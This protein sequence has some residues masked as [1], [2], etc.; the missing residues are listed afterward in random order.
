MNI[1]SATGRIPV[2]A[3]PTAPP[4]NP[5]SEMGVSMTRSGTEFRQKPAGDLENASVDTD[6]L[7]EQNDPLVLGHALP[8]CPSLSA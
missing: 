5:A 4:T 7:A 8:Q 6:I 1:T 2:R 3:A